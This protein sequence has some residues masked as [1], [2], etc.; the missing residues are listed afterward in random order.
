MKR[1]PIA[2]FELPGSDV[3]TLRGELLVRQGPEEKPREEWKD[4]QTQELF[5]ENYDSKKE[6][7]EVVEHGA[8]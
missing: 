8:G 6:S 7:R 2:Q 4:R 3:L 5:G 1:K